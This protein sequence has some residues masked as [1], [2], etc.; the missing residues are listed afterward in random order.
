MM[1]DKDERIA[2]LNDIVSV[3]TIADETGYVDGEG[4]V[5]GFNKITEEAR[6]FLVAHNLEQQAKVEGLEDRFHP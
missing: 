2:E 6:E 3:L 5:T 1:K 4:F